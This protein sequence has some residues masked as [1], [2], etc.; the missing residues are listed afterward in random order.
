[1]TAGLPNSFRDAWKGTLACLAA[2][3]AGSAGLGL[4]GC[5][6]T[7]DAAAPA[8]ARGEQ[9]WIE[10]IDRRIDAVTGTM[11]VLPVRIVSGAPDPLPPIDVRLSGGRRLD[12]A[13]RWITIRAGDSEAEQGAQY[14][15][16]HGFDA[17]LP[18]AGR[19]STSPSPPTDP[20]LTMTVAAIQLPAEGAGQDLLIGN[21]RMKINWLPDPAVLA[22]GP[23]VDYLPAVPASLRESPSLQR[24]TRAERLSPVRRWRYRLMMTGLHPAAL[25][26]RVAGE[27]AQFADPLLEALAEQI[28]S[29]W[30]IALGLL[31]RH[32]P[33]VALELTARLC[34]V[35]ALDDDA[36]APVWEVDQ[37]VLDELLA[38]LLD[39]GAELPA[40]AA[41]ARRWI[42]RQ[43]SAVAWM[44]DDA[45]EQEGMT[46]RRIPRIGIANLSTRPVTAWSTWLDAAGREVG[47]R[48]QGSPLG[49]LR[50]TE[51]TVPV[52]PGAQQ[53][54]VAASGEKIRS[55]MLGV[56]VG[57]SDLRVPVDLGVTEAAPPGVVLGPLVRDM[58]LEQFL[59]GRGATPSDSEWSTSALLYRT[60]SDAGVRWELY[61]ACSRPPG[62]APSAFPDE[63]V[64]HAGSRSRP[65]MVLRVDETGTTEMMD[66]RGSSSLGAQARVTR[67]ETGWI[68]VITLPASCVEE[69]G[70][71]RLGIERTDA[72]GVRTAW[73]RPMLPWQDVPA[74]TVIDLSTWND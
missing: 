72:R 26:P 47:E 15:A 41:A 17:W 11:L 46:G 8:I 42:D 36:V 69:S 51:L 22:A 19:W 31:H 34:T 70:R 39:P 2:L 64:I 50:G 18:L 1:M 3:L 57:S 59:A 30:T 49:P 54:A 25:P 56:H 35:V 62:A 66:E 32:E 7:E 24:V 43:P 10:P 4:A 37:A 13:L 29:R 14:V 58:T 9:P 55:A 61:I 6:G 68:S 73:P 20:A 23:G 40:R 16:D 53:V 74:R 33:Q 28:E 63:V 12:A 45:A 44:I 71:L 48:P 60:W 21:R 38:D 67:Q 52:V 27:P 65:R 5:A